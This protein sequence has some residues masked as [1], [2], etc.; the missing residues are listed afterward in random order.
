MLRMSKAR[1]MGWHG[2][3]DTLDVVQKTF[4]HFAELKIIPP[5][6]LPAEIGG[7]PVVYNG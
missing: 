1:K 6:P 3:V 4:E 5:L 2:Y 7:T